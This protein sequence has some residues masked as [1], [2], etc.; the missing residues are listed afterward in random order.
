MK[1]IIFIILLSLIVAGVYGDYGGE[2]L[3]FLKLKA[4]ARA[5]AMGG[6][7]TSISDNLSGVLYNPAG[8]INLDGF[9]LYAETYLLS[10][11]RSVNY[12][13]TGKPVSIGD[14]HYSLAL[15]W[16]NYS[17]GAIEK[18]LTN[19]PDPMELIS[20]VAHTFYFTIAMKLSK[21]LDFG[22]N[23][24]FIYQSIYQN[25][26]KGFGFDAGFLLKIIDN[27]YFGLSA[28]NISTYL[29]WDKNAYTED[30]PLSI[31]TG[32]SYNLKSV[33]DV[34]NFDI[35]FALDGV[36]NT[37]GYFLIKPGL[38]IKVNEFF[39]LRTGFDKTIAIGTGFRFKPSEIFIVKFDYAISTDAILQDNINNRISICVD[40]IFPHWKNTELQ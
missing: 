40:Y 7:W 18:R 32:V 10:F 9:E 17:S 15:S 24:K 19:S 21:N 36:Y 8:I 31:N 30:I 34:K 16:F 2:P 33:F 20:D 28:I 4:G 13:S 39:Y 5:T 22:G 1:K 35:L 12:I 11:G 6:A 37:F 14:N 26:A 29:N 23:F 38:E 27:L 3:A 25:T